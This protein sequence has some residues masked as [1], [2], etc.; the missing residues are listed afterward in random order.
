M[1]LSV[2][3]VFHFAARS[4]GPVVAI[5]T[6]P[7]TI[8]S[9]AIVEVAMRRIFPIVF[10]KFVRFTF[11]PPV[12]RFSDGLSPLGSSRKSVL[13]R[14]FGHPLGLH[15]SELS[16]VASHQS[17]NSPVSFTFIGVF[18]IVGPVLFQ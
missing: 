12:Y 15:P 14:S 3:M 7:T 17:L 2:I 13:I 11:V 6:P 10:N 5:I 1:I 9:T 16:F 4:D 18:S 8:E